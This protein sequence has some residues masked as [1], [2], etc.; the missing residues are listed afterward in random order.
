MTFSCAEARARW[1][2]YASEALQAS[3]RQAVREHLAECGSCRD[4]AVS[5][6]PVLLFS[7]IGSPRAEAED[8]EQILAGVRAGIAFRQTERRFAQRPARGWASVAVIAALLLLL[9]GQRTS[10]APVNPRAGSAAASRSAEVEVPAAPAASAVP[11]ATPNT[12]SS[13]NA[14]IYD[15]SSDRS[16][17]RVVWI[18]DRSL[19][20]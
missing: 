20:I 12:S 13:G 4:E 7:Q 17:P 3:E 9:S 16:Q 19:D 6:D 2:D 5:A 11:E 14:T 10:R 8:V 15:W 18:V 1:D